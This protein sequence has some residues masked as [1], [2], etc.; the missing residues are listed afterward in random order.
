M[1]DAINEKPRLKTTYVIAPHWGI[2]FFL[3][4]GAFLL[5]IGISVRFL[6]GL[7]SA[8][9]QVFAVEALISGIAADL[10]FRRFMHRKL[11]VAPKV[12]IPLIYVW[13]L[14]C[15]YVFIAQPFE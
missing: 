14:L 12:E 1:S 10:M 5:L 13:P 11:V 8:S 15:I 4:G 7:S 2:L 9:D 3:I 6:I